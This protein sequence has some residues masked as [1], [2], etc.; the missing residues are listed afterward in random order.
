MLLFICY[1]ITLDN[2]DISTLNKGK[3]PVSISGVEA[4]SKEALGDKIRKLITTNVQ[5]IVNKTETEKAKINLKTDK[6]RLF[7]KKNSLVV[8]K[9]EFR[10]EIATLYAAGLSNVLIRRH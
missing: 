9:E 3:A 8:K 10:T 7:D 5:L 6:V 4:Y 2:T 1:S